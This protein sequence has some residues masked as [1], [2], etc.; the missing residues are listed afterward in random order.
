MWSPFFKIGKTTEI[1]SLSGN[2]PSS[3]DLLIIC[4]TGDNMFGAISFISFPENSSEPLDGL[5]LILFY[6]TP[7]SDTC[8]T[9]KL[10]KGDLS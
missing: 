5:F 2:K 7:D 3:N 8:L 9:K 1:L 4:V 6:Q 10:F